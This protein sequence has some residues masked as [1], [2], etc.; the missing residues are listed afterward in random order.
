MVVKGDKIYN[1]PWRAKTENGTGYYCEDWSGS[2]WGELCFSVTR[3]DETKPVF[4]DA[5]G[6]ANQPDWQEGFIDLNHP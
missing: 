4:T 1:I 6:K 2:G 3:E 5:K